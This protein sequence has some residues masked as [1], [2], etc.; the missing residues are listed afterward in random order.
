MLKCFEKYQAHDKVYISVWAFFNAA[1]RVWQGVT[2]VGRGKRN[3]FERSL[4]LQVIECGGERFSNVIMI[5]PYLLTHL[6]FAENQAGA[7]SGEAVGDGCSLC[8]FG[9]C[10]W[11]FLLICCTGLNRG[12]WRVCIEDGESRIC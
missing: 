10:G 7:S 12:R 2:A 9:S 6:V 11:R 5:S 3:I 4:Q 8:M 1:M